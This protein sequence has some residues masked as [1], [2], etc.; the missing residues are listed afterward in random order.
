MKPY[1]FS[2]RAKQDLTEIHDYTAQKSAWQPHPSCAID[3]Q[4]SNVV[5]HKLRILP[6]VTKNSRGT[7]RAAKTYTTLDT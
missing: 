6:E 5:P 4:V 3:C 2:A 7:R 1:T